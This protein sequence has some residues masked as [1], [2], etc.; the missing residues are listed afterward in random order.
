[1]FT[2]SLYISGTDEDRA[3]I[4]KDLKIAVIFALALYVVLEIAGIA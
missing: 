1:M 2:I 3:Q 4:R